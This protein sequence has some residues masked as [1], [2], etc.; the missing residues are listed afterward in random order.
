MEADGSEIQEL[1][2]R[3]AVA[4]T[5]NA[6]IFWFALSLYPF[7]LLVGYIAWNGAV[8]DQHKAKIR[9]AYRLNTDVIFAASPN[10]DTGVP[11]KVLGIRCGTDLFGDS[12]CEAVVMRTDQASRETWLVT[13]GDP[14]L[15]LGGDFGKGEESRVVFLK[16]K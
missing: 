2:R 14:R 9:E 7:S 15:I 12:R 16:P 11:P 4:A 6:L 3:A 13:D 10:R 8:G 1:T 5:R